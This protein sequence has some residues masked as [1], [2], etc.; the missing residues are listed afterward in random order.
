MQRK[1]G[2]ER[3]RIAIH[4]PRV[5]WGW[6]TVDHLPEE[7]VRVQHIDTLLVKE[8]RGAE[9]LVAVAVLSSLTD[10]LATT[11]VV[12]D[13]LSKSG[14]TVSEPLI[15]WKTIVY[16]GD[17]LEHWLVNYRQLT[18]RRIENPTE[19]ASN[20]RLTFATSPFSFSHFHS[21]YYLPDAFTN[22]KYIPIKIR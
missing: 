17:F 21:L 7:V 14:F 20:R 3:T 10:P 9:V 12:F 1:A 11:I 18:R 4:E 22:T 19:K 16:R 8:E 15:I 13:H 6:L 5:G 2:T